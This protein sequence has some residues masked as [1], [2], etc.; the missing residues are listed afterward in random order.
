MQWPLVGRSNELAEVASALDEGLGIVLLG[1]AGV[2]KS[3]VLDE[4]CGAAENVGMVVLRVRA[5]EASSSVPFGAFVEL[6]PASPTPDRLA[7]LHSALGSLES[8][9]ASAVGLIAV[10]DAHHLDPLSVAFVLMAAQRENVR[11]A[12]TVRSGE[13]VA[14]D[15]VSLW[16]TGRLRRI[17]LRP[18]RPDEVSSLIASVAPG[19]P[20]S[21]ATDLA[22]VADGNPLVLRELV[23]A[24][25]S[26]PRPVESVAA[27]LDSPRLADL[28]SARL[29]R[30]DGPAR[31][32]MDVVAVGNPLPRSLAESAIDNGHLGTL[33]SLGFVEVG[34]S[35]RPSHPLYGEILTRHLTEV[36]RRNA[37]RALVLAGT[38][39]TGNED[40]DRLRLAVWQLESGSIVD[41]SVAAEGASLALTRHEP[42]LALSLAK[43]VSDDARARVVIGRA[44]NY[45]Q[46]YDEAE[47]VFS[48]LDRDLAKDPDD[49]VHAELVSARAQ[50][51]AFGLGRIDDAS[52]LLE[53]AI[54]SLGDHAVVARL[55][56]EHSVVRAAAGDLTGAIADCKA[57]VEDPAAGDIERCTAFV[58]LSVAQTMIGDA[59]G[60]PG[61]ADEALALAARLAND[62]PF[63]FGQ[64]GIM[65]SIAH[66]GALQ[67]RESDAMLRNAI[68]QA[69]GA[70]TPMLMV[71]HIT[72]ADLNGSVETGAQMAR[73]ATNAFAAADPF[74]M[75]PMAEGLERALHAMSGKPPSQ[76][77]LR[78][79]PPGTPARIAIW[80]GRGRAWSMWADG[81]V[82][83]A[84][85][86][87]L[88]T[89]DICIA[90][91]H[92]LWA[93]RAYY[94]VLR[95]GRAETVADQLT[96]LSAQTDSP[97]IDGM[98]A[99]ATALVESDAAAAERVAR[100]FV[101]SGAYLIGAEAF[102]DAAHLYALAGDTRN[103]A[104]ADLAAAAAK[105]CCEAVKT[106]AA[107]RE[108]NVLTDRELE[109]ALDAAEGAQSRDIAESR[110]ISPR[111]VDN[112]L[113]S[114]YRKLG[115]AGRDELARLQLAAG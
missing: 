85:E 28:V 76:Q 109:I 41:P 69:E 94:D 77:P 9:F 111:T 63:A 114:V 65:V 62:L 2:G 19:L 45:Q 88:V 21:T 70:A 110:F 20:E 23:A 7:M 8:M 58:T 53:D 1:S 108:P 56:N 30:L 87:L 46:R 102:A 36:R 71:T 101:A 89:A 16:S 3:S 33:E 47:R 97:L 93:A 48:G 67:L 73:E 38:G 15:L 43:S 13:P 52:T 115:I 79:D 5:S 81:D 100:R 60:T 51:L 106:P 11:L 105:R 6:L 61:F 104:H 18:L 84:V 24:I 22:L 25:D 44:L 74:S 86:E 90:A 10:D 50:N 55:R 72:M 57:V 95:M 75:S 39:G 32:A 96:S 103:A 37:L 78:P 98:A 17:D 35:V 83:A 107:A 82:D 34:A 113:S 59:E 31:A 66:M 92:F 91:D 12:F 99:H 4:A 27:A 64:I 42:E 49:T 80:T 26:G 54:D 29:N 40:L 112:H 68:E 14:E